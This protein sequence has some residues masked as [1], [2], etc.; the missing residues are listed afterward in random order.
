MIR[1]WFYFKLDTILAVCKFPSL[2]RARH[3]KHTHTHTSLACATS[4][5]PVLKPWD[6]RREPALTCP[7]ILGSLDVSR[8]GWIIPH[9]ESGGKKKFHRFLPVLRNSWVFCPSQRYFS[10]FFFFFF[11]FLT[12]KQ[13]HF[14]R[15]RFK[16]GVVVL[17]DTPKRVSPY[18]RS[19]ADRGWHDSLE[20]SK[21]GWGVSFLLCLC[22]RC[23]R[24]HKQ[25]TQNSP[26]FSICFALICRF[27]YFGIKNTNK[28]K[29]QL[30]FFPLRSCRHVLFLSW[31]SHVSLKSYRNLP[32]V[33]FPPSLHTCRLWLQITFCGITQYPLCFCLRRP[34]SGK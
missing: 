19:W 5:P 14:W 8:H 26:L 13:T 2:T 10:V 7:D 30:Y 33:Y 31:V 4:G 11:F 21:F 24:R 25:M 16:T 1:R 28:Q 15:P 34:T 22:R 29:Q 3:A 18:L 9:T 17:T 12:L 20:G 6:N 27:H 32:S 23:S